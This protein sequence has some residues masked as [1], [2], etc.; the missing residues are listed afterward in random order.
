M[1]FLHQLC[2]LSFRYLAL[3]LLHLSPTRRVLFGP[4]SH[5]CA[6]W[7]SVFLVPSWSVFDCPRFHPTGEHE[8]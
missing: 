8:Y 6:N 3:L 5:Q 4:H 2:Q 1:R 7:L